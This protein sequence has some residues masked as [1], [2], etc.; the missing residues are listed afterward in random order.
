MRGVIHVEVGVVE[1]RLFAS[2]SAPELLEEF[3]ATGAQAPFEE[4]VRRYAGMVYSVCLRVT[5]NNHDAEDATQAVFL[6]LAV[7]GKTAKPIRYIGPWLQQV[8]HR[9]SLDIRRSKK[10]QKA[11]EEKVGQIMRST[12]GIQGTNGNGHGNGKHAPD[13]AYEQDELK[14]LINDEINQLPSKYRL[15]LILHYFGGL[16]RDEMAKELNVR[17]N[18]LGVRVYRGRELLGKRLAA[19]GLSI[20]SGALSLMLAGS[21]SL[22][23]NE[24]LITS[25]CTAVAATT[26]G[27]GGGP[28]VIAGVFANQVF[29]ITRAIARGMTLAKIK[30]VAG[31]AIA[32]GTAVAGGAEAISRVVPLDLRFSLPLDLASRLRDTLRS[33]IRP[34]QFSSAQPKSADEL[35]AGVGADDDSAVQYAGNWQVYDPLAGRHFLENGLQPTMLSAPERT[36]DTADVASSAAPVASSLTQAAE[37]TTVLESSSITSAG[38]AVAG[39]AAPAGASRTSGSGLPQVYS[40]SGAGI[41]QRRAG[42][43]R[44]LP[45]ANAAPPAVVLGANPGVR[46][47]HVVRAGESRHFSSLTVG[48]IGSATFRQTGGSTRID[49]DLTVARH[50]GS[51]GEVELSGGTMSTGGN[52]LIGLQGAGRFTQS[53]GAN[54]IT[55]ALVVG[56][57]GVGYY[58][59][60]G[61]E[62]TADTM[63]VAFTGEGHFTQGLN[64]AEIATT[65]GGSTAVFDPVSR[66]NTVTVAD[67]QGSHGSITLNSGDLISGNQTIGRAG[68]G[69]VVQ[70]GGTNIAQRLWLGSARQSFGSYVLNDGVLMLDPNAGQIDGDAGITIGG[71]GSG[72]FRMGAANRAA[73]IVEARGGTDLAVRAKASGTGVFQGWGSVGLTGIVVN[74]GRIIADGYGNAQAL[75]FSTA[76]G[77]TNTIENATFG[78]TNGW[79]ATGGGSIVLPGIDIASGSNAYSWGE[80]PNDALPDLVNSV[81]LYVRDAAGAGEIDIALL[82]LDRSDIPALPA[83]HSFIGVWSFD[84]HDLEFSGVDLAVRY[85]DALAQEKGLSESVLKLWKYENGIWSRINDDS[86]RRYAALNIVSGYAGSDLTHFAVSA[87]E[88]T[89]IGALALGGWMLMRRR[90]R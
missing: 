78:G 41:E 22:R 66:F 74:N 75:D 44:P 38:H 42:P 69:S 40:L 11:R 57:D 65:I 23:F 13:A 47:T 84:A 35:L 21:I 5:R 89:C 36:T 26:G 64:R 79:F 19:R 54:V 34:L 10:R 4:V 39:S 30:V 45:Q 61:G 70:E 80:D 81:R 52:Q 51:T 33:F 43:A 90:K 62:L 85:D 59:I 20:H 87:P 15:P 32:I 83:G 53:G 29:G 16:T 2:K 71:A 25:T 18:T 63:K 55:G 37:R 31:L 3:R 14:R 68:D 24:S 8:A 58:Q 6:A 77:V 72:S 60:R 67:K 50:R 48:E 1:A 27:V 17:P 82:A 73:R 46:D 12:H 49:N 9:L 76:A 56:H 86:F 7:Q 88:P 28:E